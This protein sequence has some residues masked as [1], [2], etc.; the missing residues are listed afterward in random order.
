MIKHI[1]MAKLPADTFLATI[2]EWVEPRTE[3]RGAERLN[4]MTISVPSVEKALEHARSAGALGAPARQ[5]GRSE[6]GAR[7]VGHFCS[8]PHAQTRPADKEWTCNASST[9]SVTKSPALVPRPRGSRG[10]TVL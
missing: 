9:R 8:A 5:Q 2:M 4:A 10:D 1:R 3:H 6:G 7:V